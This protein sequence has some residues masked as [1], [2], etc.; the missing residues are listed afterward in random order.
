VLPD[1]EIN[2]KR[3]CESF[4]TASEGPY[5]LKPYSKHFK[6]LFEY[7]AYW[8]PYRSHLSSLSVGDF[9]GS[10]FPSTEWGRIDSNNRENKRLKVIRIFSDTVVS[11][12]MLLLSK[13]P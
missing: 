10:S 9:D 11:R 4:R 5:L 6:Q 13:P 1:R 12:F 7:A 2:T 8:A 3:S